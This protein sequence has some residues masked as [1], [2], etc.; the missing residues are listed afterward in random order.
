M[1]DRAC[2]L[3]HPQFELAEPLISMG[4]GEVLEPRDPAFSGE[5]SSLA[6]RGR[7]GQHLRMA[8]RG[9]RKPGSVAVTSAARGLSKR[10]DAPAARR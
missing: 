7:S 9:I 3:L 10:T 6:D 1:H 2:Q 8:M 5:T 4:V